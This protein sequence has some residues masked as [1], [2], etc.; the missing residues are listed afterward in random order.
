MDLVTNT[1]VDGLGLLL[2]YWFSNL[3]L[4]PIIFMQNVQLKEL[5]RRKKRTQEAYHIEVKCF[6]FQRSVIPQHA[7][8]NCSYCR[9]NNIG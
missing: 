8:E 6:C 3:L 2:V 5:K 9:S 7:K 1:E 4:L